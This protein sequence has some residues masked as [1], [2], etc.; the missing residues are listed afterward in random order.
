MTRRCNSAPGFGVAGR[1][2]ALEEFPGVEVVVG[3]GDR[4]A[5]LSGV[6][7]TV[8]DADSR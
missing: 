4:A 5:V 1:A 3:L 6:E 8:A 7:L 2:L